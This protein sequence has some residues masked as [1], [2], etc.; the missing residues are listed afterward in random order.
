MARIFKSSFVLADFEFDKDLRIYAFA[1]Y[2]R[3]RNGKTYTA[4]GCY[5]P[6]YD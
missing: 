3:Y 2:V 4:T 1:V 5:K 6:L